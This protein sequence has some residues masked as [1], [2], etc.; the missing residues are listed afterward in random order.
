VTTARQHA[1]KMTRD[2]FAQVRESACQVVLMV[3][4]VCAARGLWVAIAHYSATRIPW[5]AFVVGLKGGCARRRVIEGQLFASVRKDLW[6][7]NAAWSA[8]DR[9]M[10][11]YAPTMVRASWMLRQR[12]LSVYARKG[13]QV[14]NVR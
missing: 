9:R 4:S 6:G 1:P 14:I 3:A 5:V 11:M 8:H 10:E 12:K 2:A 13:L 7:K